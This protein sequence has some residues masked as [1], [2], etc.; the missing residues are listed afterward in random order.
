MAGK[1]ARLTHRHNRPDRL[2]TP[3]ATD[4]EIRCDHAAAP[5][6][7]KALDMER[8]WGIDRLPSLVAPEMAERYGSAMAKL[9]AAINAGDPAETASRAAVCAR[10][11]D[12]LDAAARAAGHEPMPAEV[13]EY[14]H[15]GKRF[16]IIRDVA[17]W[18]PIAAARPGLSLYTLREV[19]LALAEYGQGVVAAKDA[20]PG[21]EV[22]AIRKRTKLEEDLADEIPF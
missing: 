14:E 4:A 15:D 21:A 9:N 11:L 3:G 8:L 1:P 22:S 6:D 12:A 7:R 18:P 13:W 19:A 17:D 20:F 5:Y 2:M 10:G 16:G